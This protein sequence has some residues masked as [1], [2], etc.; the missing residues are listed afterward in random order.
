MSLETIVL[1]PA[2]M[3]P[4][5]GGHIDLIKRYANNDNVKE[6][7][8]LIGPSNR[9]AIS[10]ELSI[11]IAKFLTRDIKKVFIVKTDHPTPVTS[12]YKYMET[13][14]YGNYAVGASDKNN[15]FKIVSKFVENFSEGGKYFNYIP[16]CVKVSHID[17]DFTPLTYVYRNDEHNNTIISASIVR[18]DI[19]NNDIKSFITNYPGIK[20]ED[21]ITVWNMIVAKTTKSTN[22]HME[23]IEDLIFKCGHSGIIKCKDIMEKTI[24]TLKKQKEEVSISTK[25]DGAPAVF[26]WSSFPNLPNNGIA[27]KGLFNKDPQIYNT[28]NDILN[29]NKPKDLQRKLITM[30]KYLP[31]MHIPDGEIWQGDIMY[32]LESLNVEDINGYLTISF[33]PNTIMY[34]PKSMTDY[35]RIKN[36]KLGIVWHTI[37]YGSSLDDVKCKYD[38]NIGRLSHIPDIHMIDHIIKY[39]NLNPIDLS[40]VEYTQY[41]L[42]LS[43]LSNCQEY[44]DLISNKMFVE[45]ITLFYNNL[46]RSN[47]ILRSYEIVDSFKEFVTNRFITIIES[48]KT[49]K[50]QLEHQNKCDELQNI[51]DENRYI[52]DKMHSMILKITGLKIACINELDKYSNYY[53]HFKMYGGKF[54]ETNHEGYAINDGY[55]IAKFVNRHEFSSS[56]FS[57]DV[58]KGWKNEKRRI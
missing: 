14:K 13:V 10:Q 29:S 2:G 36:S 17:L 49:Q 19:D 58:I 40:Y 48:K 20:T 53:T 6:I 47:I 31:D 43:N 34:S 12:L 23:H 27:I 55:N 46:I 57:D 37:Y 52:I 3:K 38:V 44:L 35:I 7:R 24:N 54:N 28:V 15:D 30:L 41:M 11:E 33:H 4:M 16:A 18:K 45:Y 50:T 42:E 22:L 9:D 32:D 1:L 8:V 25:F 26:C 56:N 39:E 51:I 21:V 5:H